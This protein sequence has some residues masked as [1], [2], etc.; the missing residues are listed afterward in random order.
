MT[1][2][3]FDVRRS[4]TLGI[5]GRNGSGKSTLLEIICGILKPTS[6]SVEVNGR[7]S[8]LLELGAGFNPEF[9]GRQNVYINGA[10]FG[11]TGDDIEVRF[12][13]IEAASLTFHKST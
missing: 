10:I 8:A 13:D 5:I 2:V 12:D 1:N 6:G 3:S 9:A 4:E 7:V 11:L